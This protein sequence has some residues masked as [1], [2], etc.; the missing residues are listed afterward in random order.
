M[1]VINGHV[2]AIANH[3]QARRRGV[4]YQKDKGVVPSEQGPGRY[5]VWEINLVR[6]ISPGK[7]FGTK[8]L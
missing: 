5:M 1:V 8:F 6:H 2:A 4:A 3:D 7:I